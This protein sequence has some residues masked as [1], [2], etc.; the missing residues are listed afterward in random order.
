MTSCTKTSWQITCSTTTRGRASSSPGSPS[1]APRQSW[2][3][4]ATVGKRFTVRLS[5]TG[6][7]TKASAF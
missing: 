6:V 5:K 1:N 7:S 2:A 3:I 4:R